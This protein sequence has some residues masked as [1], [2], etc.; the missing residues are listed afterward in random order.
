MPRLRVLVAANE[1]ILLGYLSSK[2]TQRTLIC[3]FLELFV[4]GSLLDKIENLNTVRSERVVFTDG[5]YVPD[6]SAGHQQE[7]MLFLGW[8][9]QTSRTTVFWGDLTPVRSLVGRADG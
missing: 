6:C 8:W 5:G 2:V 9:D 7:A 3:P 1:G 4:R